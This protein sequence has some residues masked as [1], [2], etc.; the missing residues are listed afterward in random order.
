ME[1]HRARATDRQALVPN[2]NLYVGQVQRDVTE[3]DLREAFAPFGQIE[4]IQIKYDKHCAFIRF[5]EVEQAQNAQRKRSITVKGSDLPVNWGRPN[6]EVHN[7]VREQ[8]PRQP[9]PETREKYEGD[10]FEVIGNRRIPKKV[11]PK[12]PPARTLWVGNVQPEIQEE[13]LRELF[14]PYGRIIHMRMMPDRVCLSL[15]IFMHKEIM[16]VLL[17]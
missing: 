5:A 17:I 9:R 12:K 14:Q 2:Q 15:H 4:S 13:A 6:P 1:A 3:N 11:L 10:K 8:I 16:N 7:P